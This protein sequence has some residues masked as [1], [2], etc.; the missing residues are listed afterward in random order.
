MDAVQKILLLDIRD[1]L[2]DSNHKTQWWTSFH[3][4][5]I[6]LLKPGGSFDLDSEMQEMQEF[7]PG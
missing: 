6:S 2:L 5:W 1:Y 4:F 7:V 3:C